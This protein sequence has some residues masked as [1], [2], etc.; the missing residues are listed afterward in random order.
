M[1]APTARV[2][3]GQEM[4]LTFGSVTVMPVKVT[5]PMLLTVNS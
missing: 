2:S 1:L 5:L 3:A 4:L